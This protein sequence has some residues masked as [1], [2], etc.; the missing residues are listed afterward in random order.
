MVVITKDEQI[1]QMCHKYSIQTSESLL[2]EQ[3]Y[4]ITWVHTQNLSV[5]EIWNNSAADLKFIVVE[6]VPVEI[7]EPE[8]D[9]GLLEF[10]P[11][12][13]HMSFGPI[14][15]EPKK[16]DKAFMIYEFDKGNV[17]KNTGVSFQVCE[18]FI[19]QLGF[20]LGLIGKFGA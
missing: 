6:D 11:K 9:K 1:K 18:T 10:R 16:I 17:R 13:S 20:K 5:S 3:S 12:Q 19:K 15:F 8:Y 7:K 4:L 14:S 2:N